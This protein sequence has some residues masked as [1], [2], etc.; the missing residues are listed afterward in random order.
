MVYT[1][2]LLAKGEGWTSKHAHTSEDMGAIL[3]SQVEFN[4]VTVNI[5]SSVQTRH[6]YPV[7]IEIER[8]GVW[9]NVGFEGVLELFEGD[10]SRIVTV[11]NFPLYPAKVGRRESGEECAYTSKYWKAT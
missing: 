8:N 6:P 2:Y 10:R 9:F 1:R 4:P 5:V 3:S 11:G 7:P